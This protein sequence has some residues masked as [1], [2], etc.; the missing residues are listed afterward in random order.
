MK[1]I[2]LV[3]L[4]HAL[5][6]LVLIAP[7]A[8]AK[9]PKNAKDHRM[10][11]RYEGSE[12]LAYKQSKYDAYPLLVRKATKSGGIE[13]NLSSTT[14]IEGKVTSI[15]Y[16][17]PP[18]RTTLEVFRN[19]EQEL[20]RHGFTDL[21]RCTNTACGGRAFNHAVASYT[22]FGEDYKDQRYLAAK[23]SRSEGDVYVA[24]YA[25]MH[26]SGAKA[27]NN[28]VR[29]QL[30]IIEAASMDTGMVKL[31][32]KELAGEIAAV[33]HRAIYSIHFET[34]SA[35]LKSESDPTLTTIATMLEQKPRLKLLVV[36]HTDMKGS[37]EH[38]MD[39][40]KRRAQSVVKALVGKHKISATRLTSAGV[41]YL[42]PVASNKSEA[43]R[44]KN[45]RVELVE[46]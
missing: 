32:P 11:S 26:K 10:I 35:T 25:A 20:K 40:S 13:K 5:G 31:D 7:V 1:H 36:G 17:A 8:Q 23:L 29:V 2:A 30:D 4:L 27:E 21:F 43:G 22:Y 37:L 41:G 3:G 6:A 16:Q 28:R 15:T 45:R 39:L 12:I 18:E 42:A 34:G 44:A 33:G 46:K 38:N 14:S 19:Y 24:V 9:P